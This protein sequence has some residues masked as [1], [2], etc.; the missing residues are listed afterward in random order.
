MSNLM[1]TDNVI[2]R[3]DI[4]KSS[5]RLG[6][7][8]RNIRLSDDLSEEVI[9]AVSQL[10]LEHKVIF[11][12]DQGHLDDAEQQ[13]FAVRLGSLTSGTKKRSSTPDMAS[14]RDSD[15]ASQ[16][17]M[18]VAFGDAC[19][20]ISVLRGV[21]IPP[22]GDDIV[23]SSPAAAYLD[24]PEPLRMLADNLWAV[25]CSVYDC[26]A[27]RHAINTHTQQFNDVF[28]GT[29]C[30]TASPVVR[31]H[32]ETGERL[33]VLGHSVQNFVGLGK[34]VSQKLFDLL[35]SYL[36]AR[37]N[38]VSWRWKAGDVVIWDNRATERYAI[39]DSSGR[40][41]VEK[42]IGTDRDMP[43]SAVGPRGATGTKS[44]PQAAKAA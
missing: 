29:I 26:T 33:L 5:A 4:V 18:D 17:H 23:W 38:S 13:R 1:T 9:C 35:Q 10:L 21:V 11:F 25:H 40:Y 41:R 44:K 7:E 15:H 43:L 32:P 16:V 34:Y 36:T 20:K 3:A 27:T 42:R 8:I 39:K 24:L 31:V 2:P 14:R 37:E 6:A 19:P 28:T 22:D 12:R 30:E